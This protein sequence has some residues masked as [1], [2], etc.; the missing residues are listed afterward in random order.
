[1]AL[2][3]INRRM[4]KAFALVLYY[5][6]KN[7]QKLSDL[8]HTFNFVIILEVRVQNKSVGAKIKVSVGL[9]PSGGYREE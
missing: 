8:K 7:Y 4:D 6:Y 9:T 1:M 3:S 2:M 5:C